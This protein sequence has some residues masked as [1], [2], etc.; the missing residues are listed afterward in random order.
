MRGYYRD[1][2]YARTYYTMPED[3]YQL[4]K[5]PELVGPFWAREFSVAHRD[6][7]DVLI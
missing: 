2:R 5:K 7:D 1:G 3:M 4:H 6:I